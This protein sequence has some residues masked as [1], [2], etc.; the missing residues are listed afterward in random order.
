MSSGKLSSIKRSVW[1]HNSRQGNVNPVKLAGLRRTHVRNCDLITVG[2][3]PSESIERQPN[4]IPQIRAEFQQVRASRDH[5][6]ENQ[7]LLRRLVRNR[8]NPQL[9]YRR[10]IRGVES[11]NVLEK[12]V[13]SR[14]IGIV[15]SARLVTSKP[16]RMME[17]LLRPPV[18]DS[19][20]VTI[21]KRSEA[22]VE[23]VRGAQAIA[24]HYLK[25]IGNS[26]G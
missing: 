19:V 13:L 15:L 14:A 3:R 1:L 24:G 8:K 11:R 20:I 10:R 7:F 23:P 18:R 5:G 2:Y 25:M 6:G 21:H 4:A 12:I 26:P 22:L 17:I 16:N 9:K